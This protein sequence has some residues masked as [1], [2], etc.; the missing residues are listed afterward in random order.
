MNPDT[1]LTIDVDWAPDWAIA[2]V[3]E[4]LQ[5]AGVRA[6]WFVTHDSPE[7]KRL[8]EDPDRFEVGWHPNFL[9]GS[10]QGRSPEE[11]LAFCTALAPGARAMRTHGL[12][13]STPLL[14]RVRA[15]TPIRI[16][17]SQVLLG[18]P[19]LLAHPFPTPNGPIWRLP[20]WWEDDLESLQPTPDFALGA[21]LAASP[22]G[23]RVLNFHPI[24][25]ALDSFSG[26]T[27][28]ALKQVTPS[29]T[30]L[31]RDAVCRF[32][33]QGIPSRGAERAFHEAVRS[34]AALGGG[35]TLSTFLAR[36]HPEAGVSWT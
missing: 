9:Q 13:Q 15:S 11:V 1:L 7:V 18:H 4:S 29:L 3:R 36:V 33:K 17:S 20:I 31:P 27:Y 35:E 10:T 2:S 6:T 5:A 22:P 34:L 32:R 12:F 25:I 19:G 21:R 24:H 30:N 23:V 14:A 8:Q 28:G 16:D 26:A